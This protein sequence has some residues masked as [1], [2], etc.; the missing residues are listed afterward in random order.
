MKRKS[1]AHEGFS[2]LAQHDG[3]P[4]TII[5]DNIKEQI[6]GKFCH[7][8]HKV[9]MHVKQTEPHT[10]WSNVAEGTIWE[11]KHRAGWKMA[12]S[13]CPAKL[14]DHCLELE[15]HIR[16]HTALDKYELQG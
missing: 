3:V 14:W 9:G 6:I 10:P 11:L 15:A 12:K 7:K 2:L 8:C 16:F 13:S 4:I 1:D 5:C